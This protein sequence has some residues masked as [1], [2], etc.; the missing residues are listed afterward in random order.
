MHP[1]TLL[2]LSAALIVQ[3]ALAGAVTGESRLFG[4]RNP[5]APEGIEQYG[6]FVG[7]W[8][9]TPASRQDDGSMK[10]F[11]ARPS[12]VWHYALN[13]TAIQDIWIPDPER[14]RPGATMGTN[15]RVYDPE[16]DEWEMVWTTETLAG[17]QTFTAKM[18][19]GEVVMRGDVETG[20]FPAH[21]ARITF[22]NISEEHFDWKYEASAPGD[23]ENWQLHSTL[24]CDRV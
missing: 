11:E 19:D 20:P 1:A 24:S 8:T 18:I 16:A 5:E 4:P 3:P 6:Q 12:W 13:G 14:S 21:L 15:L 23:G 17:F 10:E 22:H 9:C 2:L 7:T